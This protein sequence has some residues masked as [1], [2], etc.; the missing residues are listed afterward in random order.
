MKVNE[1]LLNCNLANHKNIGDIITHNILFCLTYFLRFLTII[2]YY[3]F[4]YMSTQF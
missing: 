2:L 4:S 1:S 3:I